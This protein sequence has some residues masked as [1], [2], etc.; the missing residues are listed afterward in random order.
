M[1]HQKHTFY[2]IQDWMLD[3]DLDLTETAVLAIINGFSQDGDSAFRGSW[4][5]L[6]RYTKCSRRTVARSLKRLV[7]L[8]YIRKNDVFIGGVKFCEYSVDTGS[9]TETP[10]VPNMQEVVPTGHGGGVR[11]APNNKVDNGDTSV[12]PNNENKRARATSKSF[13][14]VGA[15]VGLG[16]DRTTA[17]NWAA[18]RKKAGATNSGT[19]LDEIVKQFERA[20]SLYGMTPQDCVACAEVNSWRGFRAS[21]EKVKLYA[22]EKYASNRGAGRVPR[23]T[24]DTI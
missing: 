6:Q 3:L 8:G 19:Q 10:V 12:S 2:V 11:L 24:G 14:F 22:D 4:S 5:Y 17:E 21:W 23:Y 13:D 7:D 9:V 20:A 1:I 18:T 16:V 15:L